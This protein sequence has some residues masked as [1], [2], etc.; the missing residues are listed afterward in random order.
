MT[1]LNRRI[2]YATIFIKEIWYKMPLDVNKKQ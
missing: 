1:T 2:I